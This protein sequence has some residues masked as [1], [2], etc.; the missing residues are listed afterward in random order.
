M[1]TTS[2]TSFENFLKKVQDAMDTEG[3]A[4]LEG[5]PSEI[6]PVKGKNFKGEEYDYC[7]PK[8]VV[9]RRATAES[10]IAI[11]FTK[12]EKKKQIRMNYQLL[13]K[14]QQDG[15]QPL[16]L[17]N[18]RLDFHVQ[19]KEGKVNSPKIRIDLVG[20]NYPQ[21]LSGW[22]NLSLPEFSYLKNVLDADFLKS[23][24]RAYFSWSGDVVWVPIAQMS[25]YSQIKDS[26]ERE[27]LH[28]KKYVEGRIPLGVPN[29]KSIYE[30]VSSLLCWEQEHIESGEEAY[31]IWF[32][33]AF[34]DDTYYFLPQIFRIKANPHSNAPNMSIAFVKDPEASSMDPSSH[35]VMLNFEL[36]PYY[37]PRAERDLYRVMKKRSGG[38][39]KICNIKYGGYESATF[40][41]QKNEGLN[42]AFDKLGVRSLKDEITLNPDSSFRVVI[43]SSL[44]AYQLLYS[45]LVQKS[46][47]IGTV[48]V[49]VKTGIDE[50]IKEIP[51]VAELD[52]KKLTGHNIGIKPIASSKRKIK[53]PYE[54]ELTNNGEFPLEIG[55]CEL[56]MISEKKQ[57]PRNV[58]HE[59]KTDTF[60]PI[61]LAPKETTRITL[62]ESDV[63]TLNKK[64]TF[65][66][67]NF[68]KYW[69]KLVCQPTSVR[70]PQKYIK[71][72]MNDAEDLA[73]NQIEVKQLEILP[74]LNW[75]QL[76]NIKS[77]EL[78][79]QNEKLSLDK[80]VK[81]D[82]NTSSL[83]IDICENALA[84]IKSQDS[85]NWTFQYRLCAVFNDHV[86][87]WSEF[88][89]SYGAILHLFHDDVLEVLNMQ[90]PS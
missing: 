25:N 73:A 79:I 49:S 62:C 88:M 10:P 14:P 81:I 60:W 19:D 15:K 31:D 84:I 12:D 11:W 57:V 56:S 67:I 23:K 9:D 75:S 24:S 86:T 8:I 18:I 76:T 50:K 90:N 7:L 40:K 6:A 28:K 42:I 82:A 39:L 16:L 44:D 68:R 61:M 20:M 51:L 59:L 66:G 3:V 70:L 33:D 17:S 37:H 29:E 71:G 78:Q 69:T 58:K 47:N 63:K 41:V 13:V 74:D 53:F 54:V 83:F 27:V 32:K 43:E 4:F 22:V 2:S 21:K 77:I 38:K 55:G 85:N 45:E 87:P 80:F 72:I 35:K 34:M 30:G 65:L 48:T 36:A 64:N 52:L 26:K 89:G 5:E 1:A 46:I